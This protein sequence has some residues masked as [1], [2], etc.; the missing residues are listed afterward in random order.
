MENLLKSSK[1]QSF[2][3]INITYTAPK[4]WIS[5]LLPIVLIVVG[6]I[7]II[8]MIFGYGYLRLIA[9]FLLFLLFKG[10]KKLLEIRNTKIYL[11]ET[12]I[13]ISQG[14]FSKIVT[15]ISL[16]KLEGIQLYQNFIGKILNYG[17]LEI[18]TGNISQKYT[19]KNPTELRSL[20]V[21]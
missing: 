7:G 17:T 6:S 11:T 20:I 21:N 18:S 9:M 3:P 13:S 19:I 15:D 8:P 16:Q 1:P 14:V 5:Y 4:H 10:V 12:H 2:N